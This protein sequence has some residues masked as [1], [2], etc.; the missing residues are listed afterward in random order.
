MYVFLPLFISRR[1]S[2]NC[3]TVAQPGQRSL[4]RPDI[5]LDRKCMTELCELVLEIDTFFNIISSYSA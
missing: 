4:L 5:P 2:D 3:R 1:D